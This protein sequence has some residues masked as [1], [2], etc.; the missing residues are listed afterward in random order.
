V[1][2][3][4]SKDSANMSEIQNPSDVAETLLIPLYIRAIESQ[5]PD[6][7]LKDEKAVELVRQM[8]YDF[9]RIK[10]AKISEEVQV[11]LVLRNREFDRYAR[12][13]LARYPEAVVVHIGCGLD[14]RF[15]RLDNGQVEWYDLDLLEV[16]KLRWKFIGGEGARH[17]FLACSVLDRA[18]LNAVSVHRQRPFLFLAEGVL[19]FFEEAQVKSL[20]LTLK[21]HFPSAELVFD[22]FSP[23]FVWANNRRVAR[24][25]IGA[26]CHWA[27]KRGKDLERWGDGIC[28]LDE[29]FPFSCPEPRLAHVQWVRYIPLLAKTMGIFRYRLGKTS[30]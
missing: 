23:F 22:A 27:L 10:Q 15:E 6:A 11:T 13:F 18:W 7:L 28:L 25:K 29:W 14:A 17:H 20:V 9:S 5:R 8:D 16:I 12:D 4:V 3:E 21:E 1:T 24:T 2:V 30:G 19:M 26:R